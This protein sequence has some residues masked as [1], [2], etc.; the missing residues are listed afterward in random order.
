MV[1]AQGFLSLMADAQGFLPFVLGFPPIYGGG[2][3]VLSIIYVCTGFPFYDGRP[4]V[5]FRLKLEAQVLL[6]FDGEGL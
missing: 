4:R 2:Q 3:V 1:K 5:S 6:S